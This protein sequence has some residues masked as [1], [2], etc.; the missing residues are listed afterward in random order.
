MDSRRV[1]RS[2][3]S[4]FLGNQGSYAEYQ[5]VDVDV[6]ARRPTKPAVSRHGSPL[7]GGRLRARGAATRGKL[8]G[9]AAHLGAAGGVGSFLVQIAKARA[10]GSPRLQAPE[11]RLPEGSG[12]GRDFDYRAED[13]V[14]L[15]AEQPGSVGRRRSGWGRCRG[16]AACCARGGAAASAATGDFEL[17]TTEHR[18]TACWRGP[19]PTVSL[20]W[21]CSWATAAGTAGDEASHLTMWS[22]PQ[23]NR[24]RPWARTCSARSSRRRDVTPDVSRSPREPRFDEL[25]A[26]P[27]FA[28]QDRR[29]PAG[30]M[31]PTTLSSASC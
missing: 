19:M 20:N 17:A 30:K 8:R 14:S 13:V 25:E 22:L 4:D 12:C 23:A 7:A 10:P 16:N 26:I 18:A 21:H 11:S 24:A 1:T 27:A 31:P 15:V 5:V 28:H 9:M 6:V 29:R 3:F 2:H